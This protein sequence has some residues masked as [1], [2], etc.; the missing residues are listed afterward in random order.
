MSTDP[1]MAFRAP[2]GL[3]AV[4]RLQECCQATPLH[5]SLMMALLV[6]EVRT[7][8]SEFT[9]VHRLLMT[10]ARIGNRT[11]YFRVL[12]E[13]STWGV[14]AYQSTHQGNSRVS[15]QL[16]EG[17][18]KTDTTP[19]AGSAKSD[20]ADS[21]PCTNADTTAEKDSTVIGTTERE[22]STVIG[23]MATDRKRL[24]STPNGFSQG[25]T[26]IDTAGVSYVDVMTIEEDISSINSTS[27][28]RVQ[29]KNIERQPATR[30]RLGTKPTDVPF[31]DSEFYNFDRFTAFVTGKHPDV[32]AQYYFDKV[33]SWRKNGQRPVRTDWQA[34]INQFLMN[35][36]QQG[37][38]MLKSHHKPNGTRHHLSNPS[39][40]RRSG[41][42]LRPA[43]FVAQP[44]GGREFGDW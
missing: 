28:K 21:L 10:A 2:A 25:S 41:Y 20:T 30:R 40:A 9:I 35:D 38:L 23:T 4:L 3:G 27:S 18:T 29:G 24:R 5:R 12:R 11:N 22:R 34:T 26:N 6:E 1:S 39:P 15:L 44:E 13:L 31:T 19:V 33:D 37:V 42:G 17:S 43:G 14:I 16:D 32:D 7:G 36:Y 8:Q